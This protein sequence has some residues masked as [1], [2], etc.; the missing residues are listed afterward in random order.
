MKDCF[1]TIEECYINNVRVIGT[2]SEM[3]REEMRWEC[4][5]CNSIMDRTN[6]TDFIKQ[7][8]ND[9]NSNQEA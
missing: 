5:H 9:K 4:I 8:D 6:F 3:M 1:R 7:S 2:Y